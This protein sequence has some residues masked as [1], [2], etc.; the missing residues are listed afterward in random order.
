MNFSFETIEVGPLKTNAYLIEADNAK[1]LIDPGGNFNDIA[2][3]IDKTGGGLEAVWLTHAHFDH[4]SALHQI[5]AQYSVPFYMHPDASYFLEHATG[6]AKA[7]GFSINE[8]PTN[9]IPLKDRQLLAVGT[10]QCLCLATPGHAPGHIA[11]WFKNEK[12]VFSGDTLFSGSIGR[13]DL[14]FGDLDLLRHSIE[15]RLMGLEETTS[16]LPG[17]GPPT[18]IAIEKA[19]NPFL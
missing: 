4:V 11:F 13:T 5:V 18:T 3:A 6:M 2:N 16:V 10:H 12:L 7:F 15:S 19:T 9:F 1:V 17:H 14:P 8:P